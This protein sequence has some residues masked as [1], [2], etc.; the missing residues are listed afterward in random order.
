M[1]GF[2][3]VSAK[4]MGWCGSC[5]S[6][7][8]VLGLISKREEPGKTGALSVKVPGSSRVPDELEEQSR[9]RSNESR[10][11]EDQLEPQCPG[12]WHSSSP[13]A[14]SLSPS[15]SPPPP[16]FTQH[17]SPQRS[18]VRDR[19]LMGRLV[20][21]QRPRLIVSRSTCPPLSPS[22]HANIFVIGTDD[23]YDDDDDA[24]YFSN[25]HTH[26]EVSSWTG[27]I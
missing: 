17:P 15:P 22:P 10:G 18:L 3:L 24:F 25:K 11:V 1:I 9:T 19:P 26:A 6:H 16:S 13:S 2:M 27:P 23:S 5:T 4:P 7:P 8:G 21:P 20:C 12:L 14:R